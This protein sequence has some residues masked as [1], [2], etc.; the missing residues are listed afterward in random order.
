MSENKTKFVRHDLE[1]LKKRPI[2]G[3][4]DEKYERGLRKKNRNFYDRQTY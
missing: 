3:L 4:V 2:F 1:R